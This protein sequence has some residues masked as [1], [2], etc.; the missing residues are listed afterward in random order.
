MVVIR[1]RAR[2]ACPGWALT[3][4]LYGRTIQGMEAFLAAAC[5]DQRIEGIV[6][7][8]GTNSQGVAFETWLSGPS[9]NRGARTG[10][11]AIVDRSGP[12]AGCNAVGGLA[13]GASPGSGCRGDCWITC[14]GRQWR[15]LEGTFPAAGIRG[16]ARWICG[17]GDAGGRLIMCDSFSSCGF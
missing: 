3:Y 7:Q 5:V 4:F 15:V 11:R 13:P 16:G 12:G 1:G 9:W 6:S 8:Y 2:L 10:P 17:P 14:G